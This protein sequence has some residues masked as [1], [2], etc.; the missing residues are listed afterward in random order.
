MCGCMEWIGPIARAVLAPNQ[1]RQSTEGTKHGNSHI[2]AIALMCILSTIQCTYFALIT[3]QQMCRDKINNA[4]IY[5][6]FFIFLL[7]DEN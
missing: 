6:L 4:S 3:D 5:N 2:K 7:N 1:Q